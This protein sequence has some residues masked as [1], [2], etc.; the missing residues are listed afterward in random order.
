MNTRRR[1]AGTLRR[2]AG[3]LGG[4]ALVLWLASLLTFLLVSLLPGD[5][6]VAIVGDGQPPERY[7]E[8][9]HELGLDQPAVG[10]YFSW[11]GDA[12]RGD[13]GNALL[14]PGGK[15]LDRITSALPISL[16]LAVL[17]M[18]LSV[19]LSIPIA[20]LAAR[21]PNGR[22]DRWLS[23]GSF[24]SLSVPSFLVGLLLVL[25]FVRSL[26]WFPRGQWVRL[27][28][29]DGLWEHIRHLVL[30]VVT[31]AVGEIAVFSRLLRDDLVRTLDSDFIASARAR[32]LSPTRVLVRHALR[33]S[34]FSFVTLAGVSFG[35]LVGSTVIVESVFSLPGLGTLI[36]RSASQG[37]IK[38]VQ[39]AVLVVAL[40]YVIVNA[41][42]DS[43]YVW[44]D[45]RVR[46][47]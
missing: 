40:L 33:P 43:L 20:V 18:G 9:R 25:F 38:L 46:R 41:A 1:T 11:L 15:V 42:V 4:L 30:P 12:L 19:V 26:T 35:R 8:V 37:D 2:F 10:R 27:T 32:G 39:G 5:P 47:A 13:L 17:A 24:A 45:P 29:S 7:A 16:E 14:P 44:L 21:K 23:A 34:S 31:I 6:V 28:S 22:I 36:V 3:A